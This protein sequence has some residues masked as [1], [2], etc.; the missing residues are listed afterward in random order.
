MSGKPI[1]I[2]GLTSHS[3]ILKIQSPELIK[4]QPGTDPGK[5]R[6]ERIY[7]SLILLLIRLQGS[8]NKTRGSNRPGLYEPEFRGIPEADCRK[9][10]I[11]RCFY[12][13][14]TSFWLLFC[15]FVNQIGMRL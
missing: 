4:Y 5:M 3:S 1:S 13:E 14:T 12:K 15:I 10:G 7:Q 9:C 11:K 8:I 6:H 2:P